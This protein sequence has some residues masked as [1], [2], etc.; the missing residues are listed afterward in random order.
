MFKIG[1]FSKICQVPVSA[2][3]YYADIGLLEP[4]KIDPDTGYR[5]FVLDQL[6]RLNRILAL[7][8]LGLSLDSIQQM[9][10]DTLAPAELQG[11][12]RL[13][14]AELEQDLAETQARLRRV[15]ARLTQIIQEDDPP[16]SDVILK[17]VEAQNVL[18][19]RQII[20]NGQ[21]IEALFQE[22]SAIIMEEVIHLTGA[23]LTIF[24]DPAFKETELD[25]EI[26]Y[27]VPDTCKQ[28]FPLPQERQLSSS[29][30]P[31]LAIAATTL[32]LGDYSQFAQSYQAL[33]RWIE[34]NGYQIA[35]Q[36]R[37]I[38]LRPPSPEEAALTEIQ[39]PII[40]ERE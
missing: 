40:N 26:A 5:Y 13:K 8:D 15:K 11:M 27:P 21:A 30:L 32:H 10:N 9:L 31:A 28:S 7:K 24:H 6:P 33:G 16:Q 4:V 39:Y 36:A 23:P 25:V 22:T 17:K 35:G 12:L 38:Y 14:E 1:D 3:R 20:P 19:I 18:S 37:E 29:V 34:Q 2:L